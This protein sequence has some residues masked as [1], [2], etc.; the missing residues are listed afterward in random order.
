MDEPGDAPARRG[1]LHGRLL[2]V[3]GGFS[4]LVAV[5]ALWQFGVFGGDPDREPVGAVDGPETGWLSAGED[6]SGSP[7]SV[8]AASSAVESA[9]SS[10]TSTSAAPSDAATSSAAASETSVREEEDEEDPDEEDAP[11]EASCAATLSLDEEWDGSVSVTVE[12]VNTG[13]AEF[14]SWAVDLDIDDMDVYHHWNMR[15]LDWGWYGSQD[16]NGRLDPGEDAVAGFQAETDRGFELP[17]SVS[18]EA[19]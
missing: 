14:G 6:G 1:R 10:S 7:Q 8:D 9:S 5:V 19:Q 17:D 11:A 3:L 4:A 15:E 13:G 2:H 16:W 18:C 12:V